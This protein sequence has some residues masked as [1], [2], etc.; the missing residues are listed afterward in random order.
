MVVA[1]NKTKWE[2]TADTAALVWALFCTRNSL[3]FE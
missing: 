1:A 3:R 2:D